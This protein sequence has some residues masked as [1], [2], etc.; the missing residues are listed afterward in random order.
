MYSQTF[1]EQPRFFLMHFFMHFW[2]NSDALSLPRDQRSARYQK[3]VTRK[4]VRGDA[5]GS[6]SGRRDRFTE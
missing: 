3:V 4:K 2:A 1:A 5:A 6:E